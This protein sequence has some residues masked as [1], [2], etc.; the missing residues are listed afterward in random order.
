MY[1]LATLLIGG[2][3]VVAVLVLMGAI[4][5]VFVFA[6][7]PM[8][9]LVGSAG[10]VGLWFAV[11]Y[12]L[13]TSGQRQ[14]EAEQEAFELAFKPHAEHF[15]KVCQL[16]GVKIHRQVVDVNSVVFQAPRSDVRDKD[17]WDPGFRGDVYGTMDT[18][19][20]ESGGEWNLLSTFLTQ[21]TWDNLF[22]PRPKREVYLR[23][24]QVEVPALVDGVRG[25]NRYRAVPGKAGLHFTRTFVHESASRYMVRWEDISTPNDRE[26]WVAGSKWAIVDLR[27]EEVLAERVGY[28]IDTAQGQGPTGPTG[29][30]GPGSP[31]WVRAGHAQ[32]RIRHIPN[33]CPEKSD[34]YNLDFVRSA[35]QPVEQEIAVTHPERP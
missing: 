17:L 3:F 23:F 20:Y 19:N 27:S 26:H 34:R 11:M 30:A 5:I 13:L 9:R 28:A 33:A 7:Q 2:F 10:V 31:P 14:R 25:Y 4:A 29:N 35:L 15:A 22:Y 21:P 1:E 16:A 24:P 18:S 12:G 6:K 32:Y 8:P